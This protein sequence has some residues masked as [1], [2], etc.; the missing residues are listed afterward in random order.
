MNE[1]NKIEIKIKKLNEAYEHLRSLGK[2]HTKTTFADEIKFNPK[3]ISSA[4]NGNERYLT[5]GLFKKIHEKYPDI[6]NIDYFL[7]DKGEMLIT[8]MSQKIDIA[9]KIIHVPLLPISAQGGSLND[10]IVSVKE[11][12]CEKIVS[13]IR[14]ADFAVTV[15][16]DSMAPEYPSGSQVLIKKINEKSFIDW[17]RT[18]VLDTCNGIVIK[19]LVPSEK[20]GC[21]RCLSINKDERYAPF[22]IA[23]DNINGIY[24]VLL[25]M[26]VK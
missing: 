11:T 22:D 13:P 9:E 16:G 15:S 7:Y 14:G 4:F 17:G 20:K 12:D 2:I 1:K 23:L 18:Y 6:F 10:F 25:C 24:R 5:D 3:N 26:S 21:V 19:I 8:D